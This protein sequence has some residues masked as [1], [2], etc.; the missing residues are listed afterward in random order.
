MDLNAFL[1]TAVIECFTAQTHREGIKGHQFGSGHADRADLGA[2]F[3]PGV[4]Q[5]S[6]RLSVTDRTEEFEQNFDSIYVPAPS[7]AQLLS[8]FWIS[9]RSEAGILEVVLQSPVDLMLL[10][11]D[12]HA[13][14]YIKVRR[15]D[16]FLHV[17]R[18][19]SDEVV[20]RQ[21]AN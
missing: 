8:C 12:G 19:L 9:R 18:S 16:M 6:P 15:P 13:D 3:S 14:D 1:N 20:R 2:N 11:R 4:A 7:K 5:H 21:A 10:R 17:A